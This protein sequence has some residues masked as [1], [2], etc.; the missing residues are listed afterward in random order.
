MTD[1]AQSNIKQ[2]LRK[3][4]A[5]L[6]RENPVLLQVV[7]SFRSLDNLAYHMGLLDRN[8]SFATKVPWWPMIAVLGTFSSGKS[9]FINRYIGQPL[10][11]TGNQAVDDKFTVVCFSS[12]D[13]HRTLPG[14]A[15]D[16]DPRFPFYQI[17]KDIEAVGKRLITLQQTLQ[18]A[19]AR[20]KNAACKKKGQPWYIVNDEKLT[21]E[22]KATEPLAPNQ[23][24]LLNA[25]LHQFPK[26]IAHT[27]LGFHVTIDEAQSRGV[28]IFE[29]APRSRGAQALAA[30]AEELELR[31]PPV[32]AEIR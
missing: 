21:A 14:L 18:V 11:L 28:S 6:Q 7:K 2:R 23:E 25:Y 31:E 24:L 27:V 10:Q 19:K 22:L 4:E 5:H 30:L 3:L 32:E 20:C 13:N 17:S 29:Y 12:D 9:T 15:L 1:T 26:E 16:A 8:E